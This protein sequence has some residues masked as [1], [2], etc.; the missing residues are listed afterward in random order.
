[1]LRHNATSAWRA[2]SLIS[3]LMATGANIGITLVAVF[4]PEGPSYSL[5]NCNTKTAWPLILKHIMSS[6]ATEEA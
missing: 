6:N 5:C 1:M 3:V 4:Y 2:L